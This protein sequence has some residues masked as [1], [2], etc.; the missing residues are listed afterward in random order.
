MISINL[1]GFCIIVGIGTFSRQNITQSTGTESEILHEEVE[2]DAQTKFYKQH[3]VKSQPPVMANRVSARDFDEWSSMQI[4]KSFERSKL[5][6]E[7][8]RQREED[9]K[10]AIEKANN[11]GFVYYIGIMV[12]LGS[13][14]YEW[15]YDTFHPIEQPKL[16]KTKS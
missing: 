1:F 2:D 14:I 4:T 13:A 3:M 5:G 11:M 9:R 12:I 16:N 10:E 7:L 8:R 6:K 15:F